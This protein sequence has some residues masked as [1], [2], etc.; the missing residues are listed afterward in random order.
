MMR[1]CVFLLSLVVG[2]VTNKHFNV[3]DIELSHEMLRS[4]VNNTTLPCL[5]GLF[6]IYPFKKLS[7][8]P[9]LN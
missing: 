1:G 2:C 7:S 5:S 9:A 4:T 3:K 6:L 8:K